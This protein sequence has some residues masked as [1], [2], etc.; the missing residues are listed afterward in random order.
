MTVRKKFGVKWKF[1][2]QFANNMT[3]NTIVETRKNKIIYYFIS[4]FSSVNLEAK[5]RRFF[6]Q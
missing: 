1:K 5:L 3:T 6:W 2:N 4:V